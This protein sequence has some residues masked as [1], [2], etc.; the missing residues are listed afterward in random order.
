MK[1]WIDEDLSPSLTHICHS[2]GYQATCVRDRGRLSS[3]DQD[4]AQIAYDE[5]WIIVTNDAGDYLKLAERNEFHPGLIFLE[6]G[7]AAQERAWLEAALAHIS[8][9]AKARRRSPAAFMTNHVVEVDRDGHCHDYS[10][11]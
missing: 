2:A 7:S 9:E 3:K 5:D 1:L 4:L 6:E 11:P 10:W 8:S